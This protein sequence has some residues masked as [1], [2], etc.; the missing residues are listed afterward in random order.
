M[1]GSDFGLWGE[2]RRKENGRSL[3]WGTLAQEYETVS[4]EVWQWGLL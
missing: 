3:C 1:E 2:T 4:W